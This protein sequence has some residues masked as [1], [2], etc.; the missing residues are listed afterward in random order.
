MVVQNPTSQEATG[1][2]LNYSKRKR[3]SHAKTSVIHP[4]QEGLPKGAVES[5]MPIPSL[6]MIEAKEQ[7]VPKMDGSFDAVFSKLVGDA[8]MRRAEKNPAS[9]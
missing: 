3:R 9:M 4:N 6:T 7:T 2:T 8:P 5:T 1:T